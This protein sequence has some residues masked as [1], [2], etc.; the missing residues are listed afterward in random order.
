MICTR[1]RAGVRIVSRHNKRLH[2]RRF[3]H[4][5]VRTGA[6]IGDVRDGAIGVKVAVEIVAVFI[7]ADAEPDEQADEGK[8]DHAAYR[9]A[10]DGTRVG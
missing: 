8:A 9:A 10:G 7:A 4:V 1:A 2:V 5:D 6:G 3:Q